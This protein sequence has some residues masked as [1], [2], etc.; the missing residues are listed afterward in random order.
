MKSTS[1][2]TRQADV[3]IEASWILQTIEALEEKYGV[4]YPIQILQ[5][6]TPFIRQEAHLELPTFG[7]MPGWTTDRI[8]GL[9]TH[10]L[11]LGHL[12]ISDT[13]YGRLALSEQGK[14]FLQAPQELIVKWKQLDRSR[15]EQDLHQ[16]LRK[17][18]KEFSQKMGMAPFR[19]FTDHTLE[20][21]IQ[22]RPLNL[23]ALK[24]VPGFGDVKCNQFGPSVLLTIQ[25]AEAGEAETL[26]L[27]LL[28]KVSRPSYQSVKDLFETGL[29]EAGIARKRMVQTRTIRR[30]LMELHRAGEI[31][32]C[33]WIESEV[34]NEDFKQAT[35]YFQQV[36]DPRLKTAYEALGLDYDTL[37]LCRLY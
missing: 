7:K 2:P 12:E 31:D 17:L 35:D 16:R 37:R 33:P 22:M 23:P 6:R 14:G 24:E 5:G 18:R 19:V 21:L 27:H 8:R 9:V 13:R 29:D 3:A 26:R 15:L 32:L 25:Q 1:Q 20:H 36:E 11:D 10:L 28:R 34:P 30:M 4:N